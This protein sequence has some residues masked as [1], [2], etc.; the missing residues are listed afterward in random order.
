MADV[1][2]K[3]LVDLKVVDNYKQAADNAEFYKNRVSVLNSAI[4]EQKRQI[5]EVERERAKGVKT[6]AQAAR[7]IAK[8]QQS[9]DK[10]TNSQKAAIIQQKQAERELK[11]KSK[12]VND[13]IVSDELL[14]KTLDASSMSLKEMQS[15][16]NQ[17][18][19]I[20]LKGLTDEQIGTLKKRIVELNDSIRLARNEAKGLTT[21]TF[22]NLASGMQSVTALGQ[23]IVGIFGKESSA[24]KKLSETLVQLIALT[25]GLGAISQVL[26]QRKLSL[27]AAN[28]NLIKSNIL[29]ATSTKVV[30][31][32]EDGATITTYKWT[33]ATK[34][35]SVAM[36]VLPIVAIGAALGAFVGFLSSTNDEAAK[37]ARAIKELDLALNSLS[38]AMNNL[39]NLQN[40]DLINAELD[41]SKDIAEMKRRGAAQEQLDQRELQ[42]LQEITKI[43]QEYRDKNIED[44]KDEQSIFEK[45]QAL[46]SKQQDELIAKGE[47]E[48]EAKKKIYEIVGKTL[49]ITEGFDSITLL[50]DEEQD[51]FY[52]LK[53]EAISLDEELGNIPGR[54]KA[55]DDE[56]TKS[57]YDSY[58]QR[59][60]IIEDGSKKSIELKLQEVDIN[61]Q[62]KK[63]E[64]KQNME[65]NKNN[66]IAQITYN[67]KIY[68][69][70]N[71]AALDRIAIQKKERGLTTLRRKE[72]EAEEQ[73]L[74][75]AR[76]IYYQNAEKELRQSLIT[77][78][79]QEGK[80]Q[81][82]L[83]KETY[84]EAIKYL[85]KENY[86]LEENSEAYEENALQIELLKQK[87]DELVKDMQKKLDDEEI[88][89]IN[90]KLADEYEADLAKYTH[91]EEEKLKVREKLLNSQIKEKKDNKLDP[92]EDEFE[93]LDTRLQ[94]LEVSYDK[95]FRV[96][97]RNLKDQK[98]L[99]IKYL[100]EQKAILQASGLDTADI[101]EQINQAAL[102]SDKEFQEKRIEQ[103]LWY[104]E[105]FSE[106]LSSAME[107]FNNML[108]ERVGKLEANA[109]REQALAQ[110]QLDNNL[111]SQEEHDKKVRE[112]N[113]KLQKE[114]AKVARKQAIA[115]KATAL[116]EAGINTASSILASSKMG[117]PAAIP[118]IAM[119]AALGAIQTLAIASKPIPQAETGGLIKGA[120][121]ANGGA[122]IEAEGG[123][124]IINKRSTSMFGPLLSAINE[125]GGGV[126]FTAPLSDGGF[127]L[128]TTQAQNSS[129]STDDIANI[130]RQ[131]AESLKIY[132][133]V[134]DIRE[135]D[136]KYTEVVE[137]ATF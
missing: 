31:K 56:I 63:D 26:Q 61:E 62:I 108:D 82:K 21:S 85:E 81:I 29:R 67:K 12:A 95:E 111:I 50:S 94:L 98:N 72:L 47:K 30:T 92:I 96:L 28:Y 39:A 35:L 52:Q 15:E 42:Y 91:N 119:A 130:V 125:A 117:F 115:D 88:A 77:L 101:N 16:L 134:E 37:T 118:F 44:I 124:A 6:D 58:N 13:A 133:T 68:D 65:F 112:S 90:K 71:Q 57:M 34:A 114:K 25:Q 60:K 73:A 43:R 14:N 100:E 18:S 122:L 38:V 54:I 93:L 41:Y 53:N 36:K 32:A 64:L 120:S 128:R 87:R 27:L 97:G 83:L 10:N 2:K 70:E 24:G 48:L 51:K 9:I 66:T 116:F 75:R 86:K 127:S 55:V 8:L 102:D 123:E 69:I 89:R 45:Q 135:E 33:A 106:I 132:V 121:H 20:S 84:G 104:A 59:T 110:F 22:S 7:E 46:N 131:T 40:R 109:E 80:E 113:N 126:P 17:L 78:M 19:E 103:W 129:L 136:R 74:L 4:K 107:I 3:I 79:Q 105:Q 1:E 99:R 23:V 76:N 5:T 11:K 49:E 137:G